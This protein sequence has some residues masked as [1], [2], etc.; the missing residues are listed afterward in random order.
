MEDTLLLSTMALF[1]IRNQ[2][3]AFHISKLWLQLA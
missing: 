3:S 1:I 2:Q